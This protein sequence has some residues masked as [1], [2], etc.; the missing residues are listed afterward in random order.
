LARVVAAGDTGEV[1]A[2]DEAASEVDVWEAAVGGLG[3]GLHESTVVVWL[4]SCD[5]DFVVSCKLGTNLGSK[6]DVSRQ[7]SVHTFGIHCAVLC[8]VWRFKSRVTTRITPQKIGVGE[9]IILAET[10]GRTCVVDVA[11]AGK[12]I[13]RRAI[14][15]HIVGLR[16][17][18][19]SRAIGP[20]TCL[21][22]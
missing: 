16:Q 22:I 9:S 20:V 10:V 18:V 13:G 19:I 1:V 12:A 17:L 2:V 21:R 11:A 6:D 7:E 14:A 8:T 5:C 4:A 3:T 15:R